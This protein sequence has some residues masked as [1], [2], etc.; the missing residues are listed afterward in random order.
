MNRRQR[1]NMLIRQVKFEPRK[2]IKESNA[3]EDIFDEKE[4]DQSLVAWEHLQEIAGLLTHKDIC[5]VQKIIT[6]NQTN[7]QPDQRG[8]YRTLSGVEVSV[9]GR[10]CPPASKVDELMEAWLKD[11]PKMTPLIAHIRF[12]SIHPFADGNGRT[13]RMLYWW[14]CQQLNVKP[15]LHTYKHRDRYY[16]LFDEKRVENLEK[17]KWGINFKGEK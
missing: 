7:L 13:G 6:L 15:Y 11:L 10:K 12:E 17:N 3:I 8:Y 9:G 16:M 1:R 4:I 2:F 5:K 14:Q